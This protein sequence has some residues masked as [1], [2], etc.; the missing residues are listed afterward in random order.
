MCGIVGL[1]LRTRLEPELGRLTAAMLAELCDRGPDSA[2]FAVYGNETAGITKI[3]AVAR[4]GQRRLGAYR[5]AAGRGRGRGVTVE[6]IE[7][8]AIFKTVRRRGSGAQ[9]ADRNVP[10]AIRC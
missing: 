1:F 6:A 8:H 9:V 3:C 2:G 7:D 4:D 10:E 5:Q